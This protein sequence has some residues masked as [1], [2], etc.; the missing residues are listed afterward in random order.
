[1]LTLLHQ[2]VALTLDPANHRLSGFTEL[3]VQPTTVAQLA[4]L[5]SRGLAVESVLVNSRR[6]SWRLHDTLN[7]Y[8]SSAH[9][10]TP[11]QGGLPKDVFVGEDDLE[12]APWFLPARVAPHQHHLA[13]SRYR[14]AFAPGRSRELAVAL[15]ERVFRPEGTGL[16]PMV[17][18][19]NYLVARPKAGVAFALPFVYT[20]NDVH[21]RSALLWLPCLDEP[22]QR[23]TW[24]VELTVPRGLL[25][26][27]GETTT[28]HPVA[29]S[30]ELH[31]VTWQLLS[32]VAA[33]HVGWVLGPLSGATLPPMREELLD[34][35]PELATVPVRCYA[36]DSP[37][38]AANTCAFVPHALAFYALVFGSFP[39]TAYAVVFVPDLEEPAHFSG[40]TVVPARM[41]YGPRALD[42]LVERT[43][44]LATAVAAQW[45]GVS[46]SA[47][48]REDIWCVDG[49]AGHMA[50][51]YVRRLMGTNEARAR[52]WR[53]AQTV[54]ALEQG[55]G[56]RPIG[57]GPPHLPFATS[58]LRHTRR[59]GTLVVSLLDRRMTRADRLLGLARVLPRLFLQAVLGE[60][61]GGVLTTAHFQRLCERVAHRRLEAFFRQWVFL[62]GVPL[63][64]A[65][66]RFN[67]KRTVIEVILRQQMV[68]L[69]EQAPSNE[70]LEQ[71]MA[72]N[73][74]HPIPSVFTGPI[75]VR[76]HEHDGTPH[77]QMVEV[78]DT[79]TRIEIPYNVRK[80]RR[81]GEPVEHSSD[82]EEVDE[83]PTHTLGD[84]LVNPHE[85]LEWQ[86]E[87]ALPEHDTY[88]WVR[89]DTE[90]EWAA[91]WQVTQ[92]DSMYAA[93][94]RQDRDVEAH[95]E[96]VARVA[97]R[98]PTP[99]LVTLL[100][101]TVM[102]QRY[103][104]QVRADA[105]TALA[106]YATPEN[107]M[108]GLHQVL[109]A[110]TALVCFPGTAIPRN[111]HFELYGELVLQKAVPGALA[112][113]R[114]DHG[115]CPAPVRAMLLAFARY[116]DNRHN[117]YDDGGWVL[118]VVSALAASVDGDSAHKHDVL[119]E[120][121]RIRA[122]EEL[123]PNPDPQVAE[124]CLAAEVVLGEALWQ[125]LLVCT[126][127]PALQSQAMEALLSAGGL[128]DRHVLRYWWA[129]V[130]ACG[131]AHGARAR[132]F[133]TL[134]AALV[135]VGCG[136]ERVAEDRAA[137][138]TEESGEDQLRARRDA[139][140]RKTVAGTVRVLRRDFG[141]GLARVLWRCLHSTL[142][143]PH[144]RAVAYELCG[145][146]YPAKDAVLVTV[147]IP[148]VEARELKRRL[149]AH[150]D[151]TEVVVRREGRFKISLGRKKE[152]VKMVL[153]L[154][155][156]KEKHARVVRGDG[157]LVVA[158][159]QGPLRYV[160]IK[161]G[162]AEASAVGWGRN[163]QPAGSVEPVDAVMDSGEAPKAEAESTVP[164]AEAEETIPGEA[165]E[166]SRPSS[167]P[168][169]A[170]ASSEPE[171]A[172]EPETAPAP[173]P[174][175]K[176]RL[177]FKP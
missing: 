148:N 77:E 151:G 8:E 13:Q 92:P 30:P 124:A 100:V 136:G 4:F 76:V 127:Q 1:M 44:E 68:L 56:R 120:I 114:D 166:A 37:T 89:I 140:A 50:L 45:A 78:R 169:V 108:A 158:I 31:T 58:D 97:R 40:L 145:V 47:A 123:R 42:P 82:E 149:G 43:A 115:R 2:R 146:L 125:R 21:G 18:K 128:R 174:A 16:A 27:A 160:R 117:A 168:S 66:H 11:T 83:A 88:E 130:V 35:G 75:A 90:G 110:A 19:V 69:K 71:A 138:V 116:N 63:V 167:T 46:V 153:V 55:P 48:D 52:V 84:V 38:T 32:P 175:P 161:N 73:D 129:L 62:A 104:Y 86:L 70:L 61:P 24:T 141:R 176:I 20:A 121:R 173:T 22:H 103:F 96:A 95:L 156:W 109:M 41:A 105:Y 177:K 164:K 137:V 139:Y 106:A 154:P 34:D 51:Q 60:L 171:A 26:V 25:V 159:K 142:L 122:L 65:T 163:Q 119:Q 101:R 99:Q 9:F 29:H 118:V 3:T 6:V 155:R 147:W 144:E 72:L 10:P 39:F 131:D 7:L 67:K 107:R 74:L 28:L 133:H 112:A 12:A 143:G 64:V 79:V 135:A 80:R 150:A 98:P 134:V 152:K 36:A 59:K 5:D 17:I 126:Q 54:V 94:L 57:W 15:P 87:D 91:R 165:A 172:P 111:N 33:H 157:G 162:T 170:V 102:D 132:M 113:I 53:L 14:R 23:G 85:L 81:K 93:Q 49:I